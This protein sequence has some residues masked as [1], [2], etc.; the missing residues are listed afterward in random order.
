MCKCVENNLYFWDE[1]RNSTVD[2][3]CAANPDAWQTFLFQ[4]IVNSAMA[5]YHHVEM[6]TMF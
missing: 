4:E 2:I 3:Y 1:V 6:C 5:N